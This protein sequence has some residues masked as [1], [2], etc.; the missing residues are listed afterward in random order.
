[1]SIFTGAGV[2]LVT[3]THADGSVNFEKM[4]ELIEFQLAND[5]DALIICGTTGEASTLS[6]EVQVECVRY[7]KEVAAGRVPVIAGAGSND[8]AHCIELAQACEKAGADAVLLV[9]PYYNKATQKG[10]ILHYTAIA[11]S[12]NIPIILY[13]VPG[14]T[15]CNLAPK[16]VYELSKVKNI[17]A[18]KEA[19]GDLSQVAE[20]A[21]LC[22]PDFDIYSGNDD[23][24]LPILS[25]GGK[26][27]ISVLSNVAPKNTHDMVV[28]FMNGDLK[29]AISLQLGAIELISA[30]FCEVNPIPVKAAL[31]MMGYEVGSCRLPLCD[32]AENNLETLKKA[33][34]NYGLI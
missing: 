25:L 11:N 23:Q 5:T 15:G 24:I 17:V 14:R 21:A 26:G 16:T 20:I 22:G 32:M 33:L 28:K 34:Q 4:K 18:V 29:G 19:S 13:N 2:A 7:A 30:L 6:D 3:P 9:T 8:T 12:I 27:V 1:M 10:L 31:N